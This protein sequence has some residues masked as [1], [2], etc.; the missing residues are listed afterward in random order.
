MSFG[1]GL[2]ASSAAANDLEDEEYSDYGSGSG[3]EYTE[4]E[5]SSGDDGSFDE[6]DEGD[7]GAGEK[8]ADKWVTEMSDDDVESDLSVRKEASVA[9]TAAQDAAPAG[10]TVAVD[11]DGRLFVA[12]G[13]RVLVGDGC[14]AAPFTPAQTLGPFGAPVTG[15]S[16]SARGTLV[17]VTTSA[18]ALHVCHAR[19]GAPLAAVDGVAWAQ[20]CPRRGAE[21]TLLVRRAAA[22][23]L[24]TV[25]AAGTTAPARVLAPAVASAAWAPDGRRVA[26]L[27][28]DAPDA[29]L[30]VCDV[31]ATA[32]ASAWRSTPVPARPHRVLWP[33]DGLLCV[34][35]D[36][37][38]GDDGDSGNANGDDDGLCDGDL[39]VTDPDAH[40]GGSARWAFAS[41]YCATSV[42]TREEV[43][44]V[45]LRRCCVVLFGSRA[46]APLAVLLRR[47][48]GW[49]TATVEDGC[50]PFF[51]DAH[52]VGVAAPDSDDTAFVRLD[53]GVLWRLAA[54]G[55]VSGALPPVTAPPLEDEEED[56]EDESA[57]GEDEEEEEEHVPHGRSCFGALESV[58]EM[59]AANRESVAACGLEEDALATTERAF[60]ELHVA[61]EMARMAVHTGA[62]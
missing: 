3:S 11:A 26:V 40:G 61:A 57:D 28:A 5:G 1:S 59:W 21:R 12:D 54:S 29:P 62:Q 58:V 19:T 45:P 8:C 38:P 34:V 35:T 10:S 27:L 48:H 6:G 13:D 50:L 25:S 9:Q 51:N 31:S 52:P 44:A 30:A 46:D 22:L 18:P 2:F 55:T 4:D 37:L 16:V 56:V 47:T 15:V 42:S 7:E 53:S 33:A 60:A 41:V 36:R 20:F 23:E 39:L 17:A 43:Y 32:P 49:R 14:T 24:C